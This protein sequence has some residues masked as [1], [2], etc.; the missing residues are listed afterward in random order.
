VESQH[1]S[2]IR[3]WAALAWADGVITKPE[4]AALRRLIAGA[5][6]LSEN[7]K[8]QALAYLDTRVD[9]DTSRLGDLGNDARE[10]IY[11]AAVKLA[12][13]DREFT[14]TERSLLRR[15][16]EG[17]GIDEKAANRVESEASGK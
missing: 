1:L 6:E 9:L 8:E 4:G 15:L 13:I 12:H 14:E 16:R 7:E 11:R 5:T 17:L 2:V 3:V 10:G